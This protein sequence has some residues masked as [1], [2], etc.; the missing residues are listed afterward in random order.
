MP[1]WVVGVEY[2]GGAYAGWQQQPDKPSVQQVLQQALS[3]VADAPILLHC[4][5]RTDAGVH[6]LEQVAHFDC[7]APR[8]PVAWVRG[9]NAWLPADVR[10]LW[11]REAAPE[12]HARYSA[13]ARWYRYVIYNRPV[14]SALFAG[15]ATWWEWPLDAG[16]MQQ[17][18]DYMLGEQDFSS[19]RAQGCESVS[20]FRRL[21]FL[22]ALRQGDQIWV[23]VCANAFLHH[24]V[25]NMVGSLLEVGSGRRPPGWIGEVLARRD[26]R[27]AG[28]TAPPQGLH[29]AAVYYPERFGLPAHPR[30]GCL[31]GDIKRFGE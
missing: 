22:D 18:A 28:L 3:R 16:L 31:P 15:H 11:A 8:P 2:S 14:N 24:M 20:P 27:Q 23:D 6:A 21:Y 19:F 13:L 7:A 1:R 10:V 25:R 5:G 30:F 26:R 9:A 12:F 4:A 17:G 29:L